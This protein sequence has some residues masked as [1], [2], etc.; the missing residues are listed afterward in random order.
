M[1]LA[2]EKR[3]DAKLDKL[4]GQ[5]MSIIR[6]TFQDVY[7]RFDILE[8]KVDKIQDTMDAFIART[9]TQQQELTMHEEGK[10][11]HDY[12]KGRVTKLEEAQ[13]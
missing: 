12:I 4:M 1:I 11:A 10:T 2:S 6:D 13:T 7:H 9:D 8:G 5:N 3:Q